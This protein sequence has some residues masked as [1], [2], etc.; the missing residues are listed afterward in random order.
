M[1]QP[2]HDNFRTQDN[3]RNAAQHFRLALWALFAMRF[4]VE[5]VTTLFQNAIRNVPA[6]KRA[7][8]QEATP[9]EDGKLEGTC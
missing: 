3:K 1:I 8:K 6:V 4:S 7:A 2:L 5:E 9:H